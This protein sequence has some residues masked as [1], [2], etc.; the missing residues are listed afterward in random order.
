M[1]SPDDLEAQLKADE[2][3]A[4]Q[5]VQEALWEAR[6]A[7]FQWMEVS[8]VLDHQRALREPMWRSP[9]G[10]SDCPDCGSYNWAPIRHPI[11][12]KRGVGCCE[13]G[14]RFEQDKQPTAAD[15]ELEEAKAATD[16]IKTLTDLGFDTQRA[17]N[18]VGTYG[19]H[20]VKEFAEKNPSIP[21]RGIRGRYFTR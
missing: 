12:Q 8:I 11:S 3:D 4:Y 20:R 10:G 1:V 2:E 15:L 5:K 16:A 19:G 7:R 17:C 9:P 14:A 6:R 18:L 21:P 13:C